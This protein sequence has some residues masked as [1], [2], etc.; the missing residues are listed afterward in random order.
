MKINEKL[1]GTINSYQMGANGY[2]RFSN[3]LQIAWV[4]KQISVTLQ[5]WGN[6]FYADISN[7][8]NWK[9][10]FTNVYQQYV[11]SNNKQF[12]FSGDDPTITSPGLIRTLRATGGTQSIYI[13][14]IAIGSWK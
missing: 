13:R 4:E 3:G 8:P 5:S 12:W 11:T 6:I 2:I 9:V 14:A 7:M 1:I 10:P